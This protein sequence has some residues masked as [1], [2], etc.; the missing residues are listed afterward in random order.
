VQRR[1]EQGL[2][3]KSV[4]HVNFDGDDPARAG[5]L[6]DDLAEALMTWLQWGSVTD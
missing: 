3:S 1:V 4:E 5:R 6:V 2:G